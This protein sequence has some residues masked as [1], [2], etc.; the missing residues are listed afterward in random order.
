MRTDID[1]EHITEATV[2][3]LFQDILRERVNGILVSTLE[4]LAQERA[5][6]IVSAL[7]HDEIAKLTL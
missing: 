3:K 7:L 5:Q 6:D 2:E 1:L 4:E